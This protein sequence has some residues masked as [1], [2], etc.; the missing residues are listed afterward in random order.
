MRHLTGSALQAAAAT[1]QDV[2]NL[3]APA[4]PLVSETVDLSSQLGLDNIRQSLIRQARSLRRALLASRMILPRRRPVPHRR[5]AHGAWLTQ[6]ALAPVMRPTKMST[7]CMT[8]TSTQR[9]M[10][11]SVP[12]AS[13]H[14]SQPNRH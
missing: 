5:T 14:H 3:T 2:G 6:M 9:T 7:A 8:A 10:H 11:M 13:M 1:A 4:T 12:F